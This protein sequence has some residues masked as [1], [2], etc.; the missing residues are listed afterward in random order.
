MSAMLTRQEAREQL[1]KR[2]SAEVERHIPS[3]PNKPVRGDIFREWEDQADEL[4]RAVGGAFLET[5]SQLHG[6]AQ[7]QTPG[8]CPHCGSNSTRFIKRE[9]LHERQSKHGPVVLP[10]QVA[11]CRSCDR[12]FSPSGACVEDGVGPAFDSQGGPASG[13]RGGHGGV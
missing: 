4:C 8:I 10:W 7:T 5:L 9:G 3:D 6:Q 11:R 1:L 12:S 13:A 2:I